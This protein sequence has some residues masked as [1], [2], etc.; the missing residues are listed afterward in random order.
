[1][2]NPRVS[3]IAKKLG[4]ESKKAVEILND[5]LKEF[6]KGP[7]SAIMPPTVRK[8][9]AYVG[10]HPELVKSDAAEQAPVAPAAAPAP[11]PG[12]AKPSAANCLLYTSPSPRD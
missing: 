9:Q 12:A 1:M 4:I 5:E 7:S 2:A 8:L 3:E 10:E 6:V 11:K